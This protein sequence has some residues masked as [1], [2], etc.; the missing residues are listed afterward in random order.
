M[1]KRIIYLIMMAIILVLMSFSLYKKPKEININDIKIDNSSKENIDDSSKENNTSID[2]SS[3]ESND[4]KEESNPI[5]EPPISQ[6]TPIYSCI[7]GYSL[8][9]GRCVKSI[10]ADL[11]CPENTYEYTVEYC[12]NLSEGI[13]TDSETCPLGYG[14]ITMIGFGIPD[15]FKCLPL[16]K[17]IYTCPDGYTLDNTYCISIIDPIIN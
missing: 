10:G 8:I 17:K 16:H 6:Y 2:D 14:I 13:P 15:T 3:K 5:I 9:N 11:V 12:I 1:I 7:D 4:K